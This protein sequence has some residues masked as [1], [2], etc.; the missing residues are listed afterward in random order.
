MGFRDVSFV[1]QGCGWFVYKARF[2]L[3]AEV[4]LGGRHEQIHK[5]YS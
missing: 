4:T 2:A 5:T 1:D 3:V